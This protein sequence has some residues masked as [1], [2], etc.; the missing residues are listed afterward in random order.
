[1]SRSLTL[2]YDDQY[3]KNLQFLKQSSVPSVTSVAESRAFLSGA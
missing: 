2:V 1:M 3:F